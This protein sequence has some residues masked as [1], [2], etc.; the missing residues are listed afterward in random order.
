MLITQKLPAC[1]RMIRKEQAADILFTL[2][3]YSSTNPVPDTD[4][5]EFHSLLCAEGII[6]PEHPLPQKKEEVTCF[7]AISEYKCGHLCSMCPYSPRNKNRL[8]VEE[9]ILLA[10]ALQGYSSYQFLKTEGLLPVHFQSLFLLNNVPSGKVVSTLPLF[11]L[12][13]SYIERGVSEK[14]SFKDLPALIANALDQ[15]NRGKLLPQNVQTIKEYLSR[16]QKGC[17]SI[18]K[19]KASKTLAAILHPGADEPPEPVRE[20]KEVTALNAPEETL[21]DDKGECIE[22]LLGGACP[23]PVLEEKE[24]AA[25]PEA[26][27]TRR[28]LEYYSST[29]MSSLGTPMEKPSEEMPAP[30]E[31][32]FLPAE[33]SVRE[34]EK[35][36]FPFHEIGENP[37]DLRQLEVFLQFNPLLGLEIVTDTE[38]GIQMALLCASNQFYYV[39]TDSEAALSLLRLYFSKSSIR[40]QICMEPYKVYL[41]LQKNDIYHQN[42]FSLRTAYRVISEGKGIQGFK[43]PSAMIKELVSKENIYGYSPYIFSMRHYVRMYEVL[44]ANP[45]MNQRKQLEQFRILTS[46]EMLLGISYEL[47][48]VTDTPKP[49]FELDEKME[50]KFQ[51]HPGMKMKEGIYSVTFTFSNEKPVQAL[52]TDLL[53]RISRKNLAQI[54]GYR[55]LQYSPDSF[56]IATSSKY[57]GQLCEI[58][59]NLSTYLAE[60]Q[61]LIPLIVKEE[62]NGRSE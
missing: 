41:F 18:T 46:I 7:Q 10:Y 19:E 58:V 29:G 50:R 6:T 55:L 51:Y 27:D 37:A 23:E 16:L 2:A 21:P 22:G 5:K 45:V 26:Q 33:F 56:S 44:S 25:P 49:L 61:E 62:I 42:V 43:K 28:N 39:H 53:H 9:S 8:E 1:H 35:T 4:A 57:Y 34:S 32:L 40:R 11:C 14:R 17:R 20:S 15:N 59:A 47:K 31:N 60:K 36:G 24:K 12:A 48:D 52:V 13:Y 30:E 38:S 3:K 54:Y